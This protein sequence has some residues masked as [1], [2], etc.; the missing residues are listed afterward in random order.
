LQH[1]LDDP[2]LAAFPKRTPWRNCQAERDAWRKLWEDVDAFAGED[3]G[4]E[5]I[6]AVGAA[7]VRQVLPATA[8]VS[9]ALLCNRRDNWQRE[10]VDDHRHEGDLKGNSGA[11][12]DAM[13]EWPS[14]FV[15]DIDLV[16]EPLL[17][18][19]RE[20]PSGGGIFRCGVIG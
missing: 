1:W 11:K 18:V 3:A 14:E 6:I 15:Y 16:I 9:R 12:Q 4:D 20:P 7:L 17:L 19:F 10:P 5:G 8:A 13:N 2:D